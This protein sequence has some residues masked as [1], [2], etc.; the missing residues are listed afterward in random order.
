M[1]AKVVL[2]IVGLITLAFGAWTLA[3]PFG[4]AGLVGYDLMTP[5]AITEIRAFYG[6]VELGLALFWISG[7]FKPSLLRPALVS[8][9]MIWGA[10]AASRTLGIVLDGSL[11]QTMIVVL[12][13]EIASAVLALIALTRLKPTD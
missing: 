6:G 2:W 12:I 1:F 11:S 8:M 7:A 13:T 5:G 10:V 9:V 3:L 4:I